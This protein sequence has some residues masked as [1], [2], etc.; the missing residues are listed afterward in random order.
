MS[1]HKG[2]G[3]HAPHSVG[4]V[5]LVGAGPGDPD[6]LTLR[7]ARLIGDAKIVVYDHLVG[8]GVLA[9]VNHGARLIYVG[10]ES[11]N[12]SLPQDQINGLLV[13]LARTGL[14]V[15]RLKGGDPFMFG[16]GGEEM[17]ELVGQGIACEVVPGITAAC[18]ISACTGMPLTHRDHARSVVFTTGHLKDGSVNLD[19]PALA[20]PNQTVVIYMGLGALDI[21]CRE[22]IAHGLPGD[23]PA[24]VVHAGT[25]SHQIT[26]TDR[27][28][29][30]AGSVRRAGIKSP[31]LIMVGSVVSLHS[32][33]TQVPHPDE[34]A[35]TA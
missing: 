2:V 5:Y 33:L 28:D 30:L 12:H 10:K 21:I 4:K 17:E 19:W 8:K 3:G 22:L 14:D 32:L 1:T 11:G 16:R 34:F 27:I 9:L 18:G 29:R 20:R 25:T 31:A 24:A 7:A 6:L 26:L 15:V 23:T 13:E 35:L